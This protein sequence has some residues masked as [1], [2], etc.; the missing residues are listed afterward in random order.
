MAAMP[1]VTS[2]DTAGPTTVNL[3]GKLTFSVGG[4]T[5]AG[6]ESVALYDGATKMSVVAGSRLGTTSTVTMP[7]MYSG[8]HLVYAEVTSTDGEVAT[9]TPTEVSVTP[10]NTKR[11]VPIA[12]DPLPKET[13]NAFAERLGVFVYAH[14]L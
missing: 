9:T 3:G 13:V 7:A 11:K 14:E 6:I 12:V 5:K 4:Y 10:L 1:F 2:I 8:R